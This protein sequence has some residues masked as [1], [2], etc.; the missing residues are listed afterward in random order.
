MSNLSDYY[1]RYLYDFLESSSSN[2]LYV[3]AYGSLIFRPDFL[4]EARIAACVRGFRR[5]FGLWSPVYRGSM[6]RPGL[7]L[8]LDCGG[9]CL[10][11]AYRLMRCSARGEPYKTLQKLWRR[12]MFTDAY[13]P[14]ILRAYDRDGKIIS[15]CLGFVL[16][17]AS[18]QYA[19]NVDERTRLYAIAG[20]EG[21]RG[22]NREYLLDTQQGLLRESMRCS[23]IDSLAK[24]LD[25]T[26][27]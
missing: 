24:K 9:C 25:D 11:V 5:R 27:P 23:H 15:L 12:E 7:V 19:G 10:G 22:S 26:S 20:A 16:H 8:G 17:R 18:S 4:Y 6:E 2:S 14:R 3:F 21:T 13:K 1:A